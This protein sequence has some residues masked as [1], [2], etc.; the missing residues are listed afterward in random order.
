[1]NA[2][3]PP[4]STQAS[5]GRCGGS[6]STSHRPTCARRVPGSTCRSRWPSRRRRPRSPPR[7]CARRAF[8]GE[9]SLK[10]EVLATPGVLSAAIAPRRAGFDGVR[11]P[12]RPTRSRPHR[13]R[14]SASWRR[15]TS[16]KRSATSAG[17]VAAGVARRRRLAEPGA[18]HGRTWPTSA[19]QAQAR[20]A[21]EIAAAGGHNLLMVGS[22]GA[23]KTMLARRLPTILPELTRPRRSRPRRSA[24]VAGLLGGPGSCGPARSARRTIPS[25]PQ[26]CWAAGRPTCGRAKS[27]SLTT[28]CCSS[29]SSPSSVATPRVPPSAAW[30]TAASS[31]PAPR[32]VEFPARFTLVAAANPC[33]CGFRGDAARDLPVPRS[34]SVQ[35]VSAE[36]LRASARPH[37]P[38]T[39]DPA[40]HE[41]RAAGVAR[42]RGVRSGSWPCRRRP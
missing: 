21:L 10:G 7:A 35:R 17:L 32:F 34:T 42:R 11:R 4:P 41:A 33:P 40:A 6:W 22:P 14:I 39:A 8:F 9:L 24:S 37:R 36:A 19:G 30:R 20:R 16:P 28:G 26:G 23:G 5:N 3:A 31:S 27:R 13:W 38:A 25:P 12:A 15:R 1:M 29:T 2:S 18:G